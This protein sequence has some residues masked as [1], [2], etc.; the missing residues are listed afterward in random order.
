M[1]IIPLRVAESFSASRQTLRVSGDRYEYVTVGA[2]VD[3]DI[4]KG[5]H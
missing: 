1:T 4:E 2:G 5:E 3:I